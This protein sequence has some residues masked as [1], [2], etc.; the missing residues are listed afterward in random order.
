MRRKGYE[1][2]LVIFAQRLA[3]FTA[4][5][6]LVLIGVGVLVRATGSGLGCPD[7]PLC[8]GGVVPPGHK[9]AVIEYSHRFV[10]ML[11]GF[12]V[13]GVAW[14][15]WKYYRHV[16]FI[17]WLAT[18]TVPL[19][20]FQGILGA[21]TVYRELPPEIVATHLLTAMLV[22]SCEITVA[23]AMIRESR[24]A[25]GAEHFSTS[26]PIGQLA[27][28]CLVWLGVLLWVGGYMT[29]SGAATACEGWPLC[30]SSILPDADEHEVTHMAHRYLAGAFAFLVAPF[31]VACWRR[32]EALPWAGIA[33]M[34]VG[35]L[36]LLQVAV[37]A[38]NVWLTFPDPLTITHT[39][40]AASIWFTLSGAA[41]LSFYSPAASVASTSLSKAGAPA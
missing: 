27:I 34:L 18:F 35:G 5:A 26:R 30:N 21:I 4:F 13:I 38:L 25:L 3:V 2:R 22:L 10:A 32:R 12:L 20:G 14:A 39:V 6:T 1:Y 31:A 15:A 29:E 40:I 16:P 23:V 36:Y 8:H 28:G 41:A 9:I 37:G 17:T 24:P 11:V 33:G 19:V 7:W